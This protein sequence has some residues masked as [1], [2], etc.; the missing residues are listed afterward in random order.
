VRI[1]NHEG[2]MLGVMPTYEAMRLAEAAGLDLVEVSPKAIPP[3]CKIMDFGRFKYE[4]AKQA[5]EAR[6]HQSLIQI[7]E[8]KFRPKTDD[9]DLEVKMKAILG[10]LS[11]GNKVKMVVQFRGREIVHP[12]T[13]QHVLQYVI[14]TLGDQANVEQMPA[15]E[16]RRMIM[17]IGPRVGV[18]RQTRVVLAAP[19]Q[20]APTPAPGAQA[21]LVPPVVAP[22][23]VDAV[24][25]VA[26]ETDA[27]VEGKETVDGEDAAPV[28]E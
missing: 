1:I 3:V 24:E 20:S 28:T 5:K 15:M 18:I 10:F 26:S 14:D 9:H 25:E 27:L 4:K 23:A 11:E 6:K 17:M 21:T 7:K 22:G 2:K 12:E 13:G 16:G 19:R 8:V